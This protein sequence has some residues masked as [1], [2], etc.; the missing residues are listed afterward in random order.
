MPAEPD[1][2]A[3]ALMA[4]MEM[5]MGA[6]TY[7]A[8]SHRG[9]RE[10]N[11]DGVYAAEA[12]GQ[13]CMALADGLGGHGNG[14]VAS[15][16]LL[17]FQKKQ[18]EEQGMSGEFIKK[19]FEEGQKSLW[20]KK[21]EDEQYRDMM[22]TLVLLG[23]DETKA[24]WGH[25]GDSRLYYF[26]DGKLVKRTLDHSVPQVLVLNHEI[27]E[28]EIRHHPD[29]NRLLKAMGE[30]EEEITGYQKEEVELGGKQA[31]LLCSDGFWEYI[32]EEEMVR[33]LNESDSVEEWMQEMENI[34]KRNG[35]N[36][37]M[38]NYSAIGVWIE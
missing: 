33:V 9:D 26:Q 4:G 27:E 2:V 20:A 34:V 14:H 7:K 22:T 38:D 1:C 32:L 21:K 31:F 17:D 6:V 36:Y 11:E 30:M 37:N 23:I 18:F 8:V 25:I 28:S 12:K 15:R 10:Y 29:R 24:Y 3:G 13:Y 5:N 19:A 35:R 16:T